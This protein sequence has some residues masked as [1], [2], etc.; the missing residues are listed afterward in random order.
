MKKLVV[1]I[2]LV[3]M[4]NLSAN[5]VCEKD[6]R[7]WRPKNELAIKI[8]TSL[9]V[10]TCNGKRFKEVVKQLEMKSNVEASKKSMSV[11]ELVKQL[12]K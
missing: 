1:L 9:G 10:K 6:G 11:E 4:S 7:W 8:A 5:V 12:K 2:A 3:S